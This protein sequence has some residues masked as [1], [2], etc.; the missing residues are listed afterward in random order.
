MTIVIVATTTII[1][2][3]LADAAVIALFSGVN[4]KRTIITA[5]TITFIFMIN[6]VAITLVTTKSSPA[7]SLV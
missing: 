5:I 4:V 6:I 3:E 7:L 2:I 1:V